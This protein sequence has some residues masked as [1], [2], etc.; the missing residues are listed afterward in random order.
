MY[1]N[2][3][4]GDSAAASVAS[5]ASVKVVNNVESKGWN[6]SRIFGI[7]KAIALSTAGTVANGNTDLTSP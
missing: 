2:E 5:V 6:I 7:G 3:S 4:G 1:N